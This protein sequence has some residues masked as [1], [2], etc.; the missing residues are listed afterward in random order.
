MEKKKL[1]LFFAVI[2]MAGFIDVII[3]L[4][5]DYNLRSSFV[6]LLPVTLLL[7]LLQI[8][9][10][11]VFLEKIPIDSTAKKFYGFMVL[12][13]AAFVVATICVG[14]TILFVSA[15]TLLQGVLFGGYV[16]KRDRE[17]FCFPV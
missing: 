13:A 3:A 11:S 1:W 14:N 6:L 2:M 8:L 10:V 12:V 15:M 17:H 4:Y 9:R 16:A 7:G 5:F